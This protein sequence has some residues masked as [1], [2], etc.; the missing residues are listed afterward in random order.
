VLSEVSNTL[1]NGS[2]D[3]F[4]KEDLE[5]NLKAMGLNPEDFIY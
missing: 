3:M 4:K 1:K 5:K 2:L